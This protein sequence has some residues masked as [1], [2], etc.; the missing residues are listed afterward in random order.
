MSSQSHAHSAS[1]RPPLRRPFSLPLPVH[2][3]NFADSRPHSP[4]ITHPTPPADVEF[5]IDVS[6]FP[7]WSRDWYKSNPLHSSSFDILTT[8]YLD[9]AKHSPF[10]PGYNHSYPS[11]PSRDVLPWTNDPP[12]YGAPID[13]DTK[14]ERLRM[15]EREFGA[16]AKSKDG[17]FEE[18]DGNPVI[19]SVDDRGRLITQGPKKRT[20][21][22]VAQI[23]LALAAAVPSMYAAIKIR[24][25]SPPPPQAKLPVIVLYILSALTFLALLYLFC[26][27]PLCYGGKRSKPGGMGMMAGGMMALPVQVLPGGKDGKKGKQGKKGGGGQGDVQV[28]LIVDPAAFGGRKESG[29]SEEEDEDD[30]SVPG[31]FDPRRRARRRRPRMSVFEGLAMEEQWRSARGWLKKIMAFDVAGVV[32]WGAEFLLILIGKRCPSGQF[33]GWCNDYNVAS[34]AACLLCISFGFSTF[35]DIKDLHASKASP[36]TRM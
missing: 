2:H 10:D 4:Y 15:L 22:R 14:Q 12:A 9:Q 26:V 36:R 34:A 31:D 25:P 16:K 6:Q 18:A 23:L 5:E 24:P 35:F 32:I 28:N 8:P 29:D 30:G 13:A 7:V 17:M 21:N 19:G 1:S 11:E 27:H 20:A 3:R 33:D